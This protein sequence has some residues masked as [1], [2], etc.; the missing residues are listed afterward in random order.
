MKD[1]LPRNK[2]QQIFVDILARRLPV[3][4]GPSLTEWVI[5]LH[6]C[7]FLAQGNRDQLVD[8]FS[9]SEFTKTFH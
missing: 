8:L 2:G 7:G 3:R 5:R 1:S 4:W 6:C 9:L